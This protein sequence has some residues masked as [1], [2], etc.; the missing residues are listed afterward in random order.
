MLFATASAYEIPLC[1]L[2]DTNS[3]LQSAVLFLIAIILNFITRLYGLIYVALFTL[4]DYYWDHESYTVIMFLDPFLTEWI[5]TA[6]VALIFAIAIRKRNGLWTTV[7]PWMDG[8]APP[9]LAAKGIG[10]RNAFHV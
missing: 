6:A 2:F 10:Q 7:Q 5:Y 8:Q 4:P 9:A 1:P 3:T